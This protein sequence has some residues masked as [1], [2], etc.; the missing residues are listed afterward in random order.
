M[1]ILTLIAAGCA[2]VAPYPSAGTYF[3]DE[4][5]AVVRGL[6]LGDTIAVLRWGDS[7]EV[8]EAPA[9]ARG[10]EAYFVVATAGGYGR[11]ERDLLISDIL[12]RNKYTHGRAVESTDAGLRYY[13]D[14]FGDTVVI[15]PRPNVARRP[16]EHDDAEVIVT[17]KD[18]SRRS[19]AKKS[20]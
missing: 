4:E 20:R 17:E 12:F 16:A 8:L 15:R 18:L 11:T 19:K 1:L 6:E 5:R 10:G 9:E 13:R 7:L 3:V 2:S 14:E